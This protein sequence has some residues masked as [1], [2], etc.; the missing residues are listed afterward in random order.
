ME[1]FCTEDVDDKQIHSIIWIWNLPNL[2]KWW[3]LKLPK[4][5]WIQITF[6]FFSSRAIR[7]VKIV[8]WAW[9]FHFNCIVK[10]QKQLHRTGHVHPTKICILVASN[11]QVRYLAGHLHFDCF[12]KYQTWQNSRD[13]FY[14][15]GNSSLLW[16]SYSFAGFAILQRYRFRYKQ[17]KLKRWHRAYEPFKKILLMPV[18]SR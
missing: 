1:G 18:H 2:E 3:K 17:F 9:Y 8:H 13:A 14:D 10:Y 16:S 12:V 5:P 11:W 6:E 7:L 4:F 15:N